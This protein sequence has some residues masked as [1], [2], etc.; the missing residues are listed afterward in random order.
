[1]PTLRLAEAHA[2]GGGRAYLYE[3]TWPAPSAAFPLGAFH[4]LDLPLLF[5]DFSTGFGQ[6]LGAEPPTEALDLSARFRTAW[7]SFA[8]T[9]D[10][11]WPAFDAERRLTQLFDAPSVVTAYPEESSRLLRQKHDF[12]P[13]PL[14]PS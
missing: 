14:L 13:L 11:G 6:M 7:T 5:G 9:G 4:G 8:T 10:P 3:L 2:I 12:E 1:M